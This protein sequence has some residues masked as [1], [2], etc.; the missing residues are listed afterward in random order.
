MDLWILLSLIPLDKSGGIEILISDLGFSKT[1]TKHEILEIKSGENRSNTKDNT[2]A[3]LSLDQA[4][5]F[6]GYTGFLH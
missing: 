5:V 6:A 1:D 3:F 4:G 2:Y